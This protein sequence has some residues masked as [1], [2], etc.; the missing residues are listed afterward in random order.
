MRI[1]TMSAATVSGVA[2]MACFAAAHLPAS[3]GPSAV[4]AD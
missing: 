3:T 4:A 2:G 1:A